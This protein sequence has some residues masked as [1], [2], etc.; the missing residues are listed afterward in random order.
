MTI[1][2]LLPASPTLVEHLFNHFI[3][4]FKPFP[5]VRHNVLQRQKSETR[6]LAWAFTDVSVLSTSTQG[7]QDTMSCQHKVIKEELK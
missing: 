7:P 2:H 3:N 6:V 5:D 1:L 4:V